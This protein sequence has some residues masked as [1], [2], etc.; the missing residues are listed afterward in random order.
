[1]IEWNQ[2]QEWRY[3]R[4]PKLEC[5]LVL[6]G[7]TAG[8]KKPSCGV[9]HLEYGQEYWVTVNLMVARKK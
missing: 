8:N 3:L 1:M 2:L 5:Q 6:D 9:C 4:R 7:K